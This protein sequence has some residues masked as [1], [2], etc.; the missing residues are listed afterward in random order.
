MPLPLHSFEVSLR[1][2][3]DSPKVRKTMSGI[4][5]VLNERRLAFAQAQ[6]LW[7]KEQ[8]RVARKTA[9]GKGPTGNNATVTEATAA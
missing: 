8:A 1:P 3:I 7:Q 6:E 5:L 9:P 2:I 4:K